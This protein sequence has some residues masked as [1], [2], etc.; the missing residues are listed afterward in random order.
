VRFLFLEPVD[1]PGFDFMVEANIGGLSQPLGRDLIQVLE[2]SKGPTVE[3]VLGNIRKRPFN[4][5]LGEKRAL[6]TVTRVDYKFSL[7]RIRSIH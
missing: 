5:A 6:Q 4:F 1:G 2:R 3:Q 7:L